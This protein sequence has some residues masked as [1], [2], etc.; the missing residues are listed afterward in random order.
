MWIRVGLDNGAVHNGRTLEYTYVEGK[1]CKEY[2]FD[3]NAAEL[4]ENDG[5]LTEMWSK[6]DAVFDWGDCDYF[7]AEKCRKFKEWLTMR[8]K[9]PADVKLRQVYE[10]MLEMANLAIQCDTGISFDF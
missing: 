8:L 4:L 5:F 10:N 6:M 2:F 9:Q 7:P 1:H 3:D